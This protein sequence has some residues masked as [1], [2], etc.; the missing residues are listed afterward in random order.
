MPAAE[1]IRARAQLLDVAIERYRADHG[2]YPCDAER[3]YNNT[4]RE[5][6]L[7]RQLTEFT[8]DDGKPSATADAEYRFGPYLSEVPADPVTGSRRIVIDGTRARTWRRL[9]ADVGAGNGGGG[10]YYEVRT[11]AFVANHGRGRAPRLATTY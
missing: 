5:D 4:G 1:V 10:W 3:D 2:W 11:G 7:H 9:H 6:L 8:R